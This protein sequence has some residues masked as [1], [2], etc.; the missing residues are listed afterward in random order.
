MTEQTKME[1]VR[2]P[3][4]PSER[5]ENDLRARLNSDEFP[6]G[7][8]LPT[9]ADLAEVYEVAPETVRRVLRKLEGEGLVRIVARWGI[10]KVLSLKSVST[11]NVALGSRTDQSFRSARNLGV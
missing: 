5:V 3:M 7:R 4:R 1:G 9:L 6:S 8:Q 10:F 11:A 2:Q